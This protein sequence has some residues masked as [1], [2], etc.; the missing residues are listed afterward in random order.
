MGLGG[1]GFPSYGNQGKLYD[2]T[3]ALI[4][5][6][7]LQDSQEVDLGVFKEVSEEASLVWDQT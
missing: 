7:M 4:M 5:Q 6:P 3:Y 2:L 1:R